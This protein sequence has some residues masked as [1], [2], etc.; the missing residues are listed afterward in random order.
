MARRSR[1]TR[2]ELQ[3]LIVEATLSLVREKG[4]GHVTA[5]RIAE[6]IGYTPGML[7]AAF[8]NLQEILL[9][10]NAESLES[11]HADCVSAQDGADGP[12]ASLRAMGLAYLGFAERRTHQFDLLFQRMEVDDLSVPPA[13]SQRIR[14]LFELVERQ[15]A[16]L[17][18]A[19]DDVALQVGARALW[20]GVHGTAALTL[21]RQLY[22]DR[23]H[24]DREIVETLITRFLDSWRQAPS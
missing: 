3:A 16:T 17:A 19:A 13:L 1:H 23:P 11:L 18:P 21:S 7:Y 15:L 6:V 12:E 4:A 10:V 9:H 5:R 24:A 20:S 22:I 2:E 14:S 8:T